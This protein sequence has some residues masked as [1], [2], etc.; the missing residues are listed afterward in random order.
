MYVKG[1][2]MNIKKFAEGLMI[3][4][5]GILAYFGIK[6]FYVGATVSVLL[7]VLGLVTCVKSLKKYV[8]DETP[9]EFYNAFSPKPTN[10]LVFAILGVFVIVL[11]SSIS[12]GR[13]EFC[14]GSVDLAQSV[15][16][17]FYPFAMIFSRLGFDMRVCGMFVP[18]LAVIHLPYWYVISGCIVYAFRKINPNH[19]HHHRKRSRKTKAK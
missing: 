19:H 8:E 18:I 15:M 16:P 13:L 6:S 9:K 12:P 14:D 1:P 2:S 7:I 3:I 5:L 17:I 10:L 4:V 11:S